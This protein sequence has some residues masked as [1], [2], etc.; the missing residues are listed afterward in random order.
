VESNK[1][2]IMLPAAPSNHAIKFDEVP[3]ELPR[4]VVPEDVDVAQVADI[5]VKKLN[6]LTLDSLTEKVVFRDFLTFTD[7][8]RTL[9]LRDRVYPALKELLS[10]K[11]C[12]PFR[13]SGTGPRIIPFGWIDFDVLF[14]VQHGPLTGSGA[15]FVSVLQGPD[16]EWRIWMLRTWLEAFEGHGHPDET[17]SPNQSAP[18]TNGTFDANDGMYG[19][20]IIGG[21]QAGLSTAGR[22]G[23]LGVNYLLIEKT[24]QVGDVW[25]NRYDSLRWHTPKEYGVLPFEWRYPTE[26]DKCLP[27]KRIG[28]GHE[29]WAKHFGINIRTN[30]TVTSAN[31][32]EKTEIWTVKVIEPEGEQRYT[33]KNLVLTIGPGFAA[34][35]IPAWAS[36]ENIKD[37]GFTGTVSHGSTW[38]SAQAWAGKRGIVV[39]VANTGHDIAEDMA[40]AGMQTTMVQRGPTFVMP[41]EWMHAAMDRDYHDQKPTTVADREQAT[42]PNKIT[43]EIVNTVVHGLVRDNPERF[44]A[45]ER[46]GFKVNRFGDLYE[47]LFERFGGH[48][49]DHGGSARIASGEIKVKS[50]PVKS[51][52][53]DGLVCEDGTVIPADVIVVA[54][55]FNHDFRVDAG[56]LIGQK[57][58]NLMGEY[59]GLDSEGEMKAF[60][61][62]GGLNCSTMF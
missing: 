62:P 27:T 42:F 43:R 15:G 13:L 16:G 9:A 50:A 14:T 2:S 28:A 22:L 51:L 11:K 10:R 23:A 61:R 46:Q 21:G 35:Q 52:S 49:I 6:E 12:S 31:Y 29:A 60:A 39:G 54:T 19:A 41:M 20:I 45:L 32:D 36:Q 18:T 55:G 4:A 57:S 59:G 8:I 38:R 5:A 58:A 56:R 24:A 33:S 17:N 48:Y 37:S 34:P 30:T 1:I 47:C 44:D 3:G 40:N 7:S 53:Q 25:R 26:D